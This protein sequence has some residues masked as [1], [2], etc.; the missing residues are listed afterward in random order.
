[1]RE[2]AQDL[3]LGEVRLVPVLHAVLLEGSLLP[4]HR[5]DPASCHPALSHHRKATATHCG[6]HTSSRSALKEQHVQRHLLHTAHILRPPANT[7][8]APCPGVHPKGEHSSYVGFT[9]LFQLLSPLGSARSP[10]PTA[11]VAAGEGC[12]APASST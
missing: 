7:Q 4:Y 11:R 6:P 3:C 1:M 5:P 10:P 12:T 2:D 8:P 9:D